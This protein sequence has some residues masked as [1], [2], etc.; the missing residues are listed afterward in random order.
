M[1]RRITFIKKCGVLFFALMIMQV[2]VKAAT[3]TAVASGNFSSAATWGG[4]A[5]TTNVLLDNIVIPSGIT[6]TLDQDVR[7]NGIL[8]TLDVN[9]TLNSSSNS[10]LILT[11]GTLSG[12]GTIDVDSLVVDLT[13]GFTFTGSIIADDFSSLAS[14]VSSSA[15]ITVTNQLWLAAGSSL[16]F[17]TNGSLTVNN[18][19]TIVITGNGLFTSTSGSVNLT[20]NYNVMYNG[21]SSTSGLELTGTGLQSVTLNLASNSASVTLSTDV[22]LNGT[23]SLQSGMLVLDGNDLAIGVNGDIAVGG[24]GAVVS[25]SASNISINAD[26]GTAGSLYFTGNNNAVGNLVVN[27]GAGNQTGISGTLYIAD[28]LALATGT[29]NISNSTITLN[30][31][32]S[33]NGGLFSNA[34]TVLA[35]TT[36]AGLSTDLRFVTGGQ[37]I[38]TLNVNVGAGTS[39]SLGSALT[40]STALTLGAGSQF[41]VSDDQL[42]I[43]GTILGTGTFTTNSGTSLIFNTSTNNDIHFTSVNGTVGTFAL[44]SS[45]YNVITVLNGNLTVI[46][47]LTL[48]EGRLNLNNNDLTVNGGITAGGNGAIIS[49]N[50]SNI[51][52]NTS[53]VLNGGLTF[54]GN[55]SSVGTL[56][57]N[58]GLGNSLMINTDLHI[59]DALVM[60]GGTIDIDDNDLYIAAG[61]TVTGGSEDN[62]VIT[63]EGGSLQMAISANNSATFHVGTASNYAPAMIELNSG[64]GSGNVGVSV[65]ADV[66]AHGITGA[67]LSSNQSVVDATWFIETDATAN[68]NLDIELWWSAAMEV[69]SF[70]RSMAY[71]SHYTNNAWDATATAS[72]TTEAN[73]MFSI[74]RDGITS[75]SPFA[76]FDN[77]TVTGIKEAGNSV[78]FNMYPVPANNAISFTYNDAANSDMKVDIMDVQGSVISTHE[79]GNSNTTVSVSNLASGTYLARVYNNN[80]N[81]VQR[82][83]KL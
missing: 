14:G 53:T 1:S 47:S 26:G 4:N 60:Q 30:G 28:N 5:P 59:A 39:V 41:N 31:A 42:T 43:A 21:G 77:N 35:I 23:L 18:N 32:L 29:L 19:A 71:V 24:S 67:D 22:L 70:N 82:F 52:V 12:A 69:N 49:N 61:A 8:S 6:V 38:G 73:G 83:T 79:L 45:E 44:N 75:L 10:A 37:V 66:M 7:I 20:G 40:V 74:R 62:Y 48:Q 57:V 25:T 81:S 17:V 68:V 80:V 78:E 16:D 76:V 34:G 27:V 2:A 11:A 9:G 64:S 55:N 72:A 56:T 51:T 46:T 65:L 58:V 33:G 54:A 3:F 50:N 15:D 13:T 63:S 36:N